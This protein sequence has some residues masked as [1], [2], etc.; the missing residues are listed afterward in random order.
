LTEVRGQSI[1]V[2]NKAEQACRVL[3]IS[4]SSF[5]LTRS[6]TTQTSTASRPFVLSP[7][8]S[9]RPITP[10]LHSPLLFSTTHTM[11]SARSLILSLLATLVLLQLALAGTI[12]PAQQKS[13][14]ASRTP[15]TRPLNHMTTARLK[16]LA[17]RPKDYKKRQQASATPFPASEGGY[18]STGTV[19]WAVYT[20][21]DID[22]SQNTFNTGFPTQEACH[23]KCQNDSS[24]SRI[25][26]LVRLGVEQRLEEDRQLMGIVI[27]SSSLRGDDLARR[28]RQRLLHLSKPPRILPYH[29]ERVQGECEGSDVCAERSSG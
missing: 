29:T 14:I 25:L 24:K 8:H 3:L 17:S 11:W 5:Y 16:D 7:E 13:R 18:V 20:N 1:R 19:P 28:Q 23:L 26:F 2:Y 4:H 15:R 9:S 12:P 27:S 21:L 6:C 22:C 10:P